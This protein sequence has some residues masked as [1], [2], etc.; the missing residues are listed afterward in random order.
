[1]DLTKV[2]DSVRQERHIL[3]SVEQTQIKHFSKVDANS[4]YWHITLDPDSAKL[5]TF[6]TPF[7][8]IAY[9]S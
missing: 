4:G 1:M 5:T 6:I 3:P 9:S 2:N 8:S 7:G